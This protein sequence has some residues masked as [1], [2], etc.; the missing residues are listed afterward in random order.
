MPPAFSDEESDSNSVAS[1][2]SPPMFSIESEQGRFEVPSSSEEDEPSSEMGPAFYDCLERATARPSHFFSYP[3]H[4]TVMKSTI[5]PSWQPGQRQPRGDWPVLGV[6]PNRAVRGRCARDVK[7]LGNAHILRHAVHT[8][9]NKNADMPAIC[10]LRKRNVCMWRR[11]LPS[12]L[13]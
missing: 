9:K 13:V 10:R 11:S 5:I 3:D 4:I 8:I 6:L 1:G 12:S 2:A 7:Y